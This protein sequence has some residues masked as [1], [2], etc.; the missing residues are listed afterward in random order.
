MFADVFTF[1][2]VLSLAGR[3]VNFDIVNGAALVN[4]VFE[5]FVVVGRK[6]FVA[7]LSDFPR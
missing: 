5:Q 4:L 7:R 3:A 6:S 1:A 2:G